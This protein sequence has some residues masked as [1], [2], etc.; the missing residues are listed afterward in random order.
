M[1]SAGS[2]PHLG[3][4]ATHL[5]SSYMYFEFHNCQYQAYKE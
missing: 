4:L 3:C 5:P 1:Q 2:Q